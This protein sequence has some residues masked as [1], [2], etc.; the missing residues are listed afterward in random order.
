MFSLKIKEDNQKGASHLKNNKN[1]LH[2][3]REKKDIEKGEM[4]SEKYK[5]SLMR[6]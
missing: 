3:K 2:S 1:S 6:K 4:K 5:K